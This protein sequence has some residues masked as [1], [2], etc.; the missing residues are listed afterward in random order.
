MA[1]SAVQ[2]KVVAE[3]TGQA[4]IRKLIAQGR[5]DGVENPFDPN[6]NAQSGLTYDAKTGMRTGLTPEEYIRMRQFDADNPTRKPGCTTLD[7]VEKKVMVE[8]LSK[9]KELTPMET[10]ILA[11]LK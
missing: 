6:P 10:K 4:N 9:K 11:E 7:A 1:K 8:F 2:T 5:L 3:N